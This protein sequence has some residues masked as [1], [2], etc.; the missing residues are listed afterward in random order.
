MLQVH[1][2]YQPSNVNI[3]VIRTVQG[4]TIGEAISRSSAAPPIAPQDPTRVRPA[5]ESDSGE[6]V[7]AL[8][9]VGLGPPG[10]PPDIPSKWTPGD[11]PC[12]PRASHW[13][14]PGLVLHSLVASGPPAFFSLST[15]P[16]SEPPA[17]VL[18]ER[19][20]CAKACEAPAHLHLTC[21]SPANSSSLQ[22]S[23][24]RSSL[25]L[26]LFPTSIFSS[27]TTFVHPP[28][29][30]F[31]ILSC[32]ISSPT[33]K[34]PSSNPLEA[35]LSFPFR[36]SLCR[37]LQNRFCHFDPLPT[38]PLTSRFDRF[39]RF[40]TTLLPANTTESPL[41]PQSNRRDTHDRCPPRIW[42]P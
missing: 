4:G 38:S 6:E 12:P 18:A 39:Q 3:K 40:I 11:P 26:S 20:T 10:R 36:S 1:G 16:S 15:H 30:R 7:G 21:S 23:N 28:S 19:C 9:R 24:L 34:S 41:A 22:A 8:G 17:P 2:I 32:S 13:R 35:V 29:E 14:H 37:S 25:Q 27:S 31:P 33:S 5:K 42:C